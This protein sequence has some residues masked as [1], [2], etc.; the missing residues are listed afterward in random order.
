[1]RLVIQRVIQA[2][3]TSS[4]VDQPNVT[5]SINKGLMILVGFETDDTSREVDAMY[6]YLFKLRLFDKD[7]KRNI[8]N[9][10]DAQ[11]DMLFVSQ[12]TLMAKVKSGR[13]TFHRAMNGEQAKDMFTK[14]VEMCREGLPKEC[15]VE[16]GIFGAYMKVDLINDG[17]FTIC[18]TCKEGKCDT[19]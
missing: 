13:P 15:L 1:M 19:W 5:S 12:F 2:S 6:K 8:I 9:T 18:V 14:F 7:M 10:T 17:P 3:V 4:I 16:S 11:M